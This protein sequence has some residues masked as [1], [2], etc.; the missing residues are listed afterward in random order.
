MPIKVLT[1]KRLSAFQKVKQ[2]DNSNSN[3]N[4]NKRKGGETA[5]IN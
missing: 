4:L 1:F 5:R 3:K 2:C